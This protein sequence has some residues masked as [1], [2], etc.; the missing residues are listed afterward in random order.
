LAKLSSVLAACFVF[1]SFVILQQI[2]QLFTILTPFHLKKTKQQH[3]KAE[4]TL[5]NS[6]GTAT[7]S[8][9]IM[10]RTAPHIK[11]A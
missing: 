7:T 2:T 1:L 11:I 9:I 10:L 6:M 3:S 8:A 4:F 5:G